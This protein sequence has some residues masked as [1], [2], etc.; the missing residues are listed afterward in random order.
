MNIW[1]TYFEDKHNVALHYP[2]IKNMQK[3]T[4]ENFIKILQ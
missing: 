2:W 4:F 1:L 3:H